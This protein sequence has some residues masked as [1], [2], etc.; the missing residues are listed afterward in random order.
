MNPIKKILI[1]IALIVIVETVIYFFFALCY[2]EVNWLPNSGGFA[3][4]I[5][6]GLAF[7]GCMSAVCFVSSEMED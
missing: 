7:F 4:F 5:Y 6:S 3:R 1:A 2:W